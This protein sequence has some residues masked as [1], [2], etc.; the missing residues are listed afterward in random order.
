MVFTTQ[1]MKNI[2]R[3]INNN[4]KNNDAHLMIENFIDKVKKNEG[5]LWKMH[6]N[7]E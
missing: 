4:E 5:F 2:R 1:N 3:T 6:K 7:E